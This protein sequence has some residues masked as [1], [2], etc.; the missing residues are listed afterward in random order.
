ML[1]EGAL[2]ANSPGMPRSSETPRGPRLERRLG[3]RQ[4][5]AASFG[6]AS[7]LPS[8]FAL[9]SPRAL[10]GNPNLAPERVSAETLPSSAP[11]SPSARGERR[12]LPPG[13]RDR[14]D[15]DFDVFQLVNRSRVRA[16]G[17]EVVVPVAGARSFY[18]EGRGTW[19][20]ARE[21]SGAPLLH[22]PR[23]TGGGAIGWRPGTRASVQVQWRGVSSSLDE[24]L[25]VPTAEAWR[26]MA[27]SEPRARSDGG[28]TGRSGAPPQRR[29]P[30]LRD[31]HRLPGSR[32]LVLAGVGLGALAVILLYSGQPWRGKR[33]PHHRRRAGHPPRL[34]GGSGVRGIR[35]GLGPR[36]HAG[37]DDRAAGEAGPRHPGHPDAG[38]RRPQGLRAH[39]DRQRLRHD[40]DPD[41]FGRP[42]R[43]HREAIP[44]HPI[45]GCWRSPL[46]P[47]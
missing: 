21:L 15:F 45:P 42:S 18:L 22:R 31:P 25:T 2:R 28:A 47:P 34:E 11:S 14:V 7:K 16:E 38:R 12:V 40:A 5:V 6:R 9:S 43:R 44:Q 23:W 30:G 27:F 19:L 24:Q 20:Q 35:G 32:P 29:E 33:H 17:G 36:Y 4:P 37:A 3:G 8:F 46:S 39:A 1:L 41:L 10:G 13:I 26:A